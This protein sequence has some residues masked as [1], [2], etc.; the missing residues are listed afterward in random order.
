MTNKKR[1]FSSI[2]RIHLIPTLYN[3]GAE[4]TL[5]NIYRNIGL[6]ARNYI[7]SSDFNNKRI[8]L[9]EK[10]HLIYLPLYPSNIINLILSIKKLCSIIDEFQIDIIHSH[11]RFTSLVGA[12]AAYLKKI[13]FVC[14]AHDLTVSHRFFG[15]FAYSKLVMVYSNAVQSHLISYFGI[16]PDIIHRITM[17]IEPI[18]P[19]ESTQ[20]CHL[21]KQLNYG[22]ND[23]VIGFAGRLDEEKG[24]DVFVNAIPDVL[25][26]FPKT[27]FLL[28]GDGPMR[29]EMVA[30]AQ[31]LYI[32]DHVNF[33]GWQDNII[34]WISCADIMVVP[35][36]R[37]GFGKVALESLCL[38]KPV[39]ASNVGGLPELVTHENNGLIIPPSKSSD[40]ADAI[41]KLLSDGNLLHRLTKNAT[42][43]VSSRFSMSEMI[44]EISNCYEF[45]VSQNTN[46]R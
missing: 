19:I 3:G 30:L 14:T 37:E 31:T 23:V 36:I 29:K 17:G 27:K 20:V 24:I 43:S 18:V 34:P 8:K 25:N 7:G 15:R 35:S 45:I 42:A 11:H 1:K 13:S 32:T 38:G 33:L 21:R 2:I 26:K 4:N 28:I 44:I 6:P 16:S 10:D 12:A 41:I 9:N 46:G 40:I 5:I 22:D 39:V